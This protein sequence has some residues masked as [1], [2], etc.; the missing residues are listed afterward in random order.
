MAK[1][2]PIPNP[3]NLF[4]RY[5]KEV[6][7]KEEVSNP[8][9][10]IVIF[11][12]SGEW[13]GIDIAFVRSVIPAPAIIPLPYLPEHILGIVHVRGNLFSVTDLRLLFGLPADELREKSRIFL[14]ESSGVA[15]G[16]LV[17]GFEEAIEVPLSK[18]EAPIA[19]LPREKGDFVAGQTEWN[20]KLI[21]LLD[22]PKLID[23]TKTSV[24][25]AAI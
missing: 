9:R 16:L 25:Q 22:I 4:S 23:L 10:K 15:T 11:G 12:L 21:A 2:E 17:D 3:E 8:T 14:V 18:I 20:G 13:Y 5:E 7:G 6:Y 24:A 1:P 19:T